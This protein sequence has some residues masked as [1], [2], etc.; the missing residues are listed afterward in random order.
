MPTLIASGSLGRMPGATGSSTQGHLVYAVNSGVWYFFTVTA[1]A[2]DSGTATGA[3]QSTTQFQDTSKS[4]TV[5]QWANFYLYE[6]GGT[7]SGQVI[8]IASNTSNTLTFG[9]ID[10]YTP[11]ASVAGSTIYEIIDARRLRAWVSSGSD[12]STATWSEAT[13]SAGGIV[14]DGSAAADLQGGNSGPGGALPGGGGLG[15]ADGRL[16][17]IG[18]ANISSVDVVQCLLQSQLHWFTQRAR[19]RL[20]ATTITWD[21]VG[22]GSGWISP[23][24]SN[25]GIPFFPAGMAVAVNSNALWF[26]ISGNAQPN[27]D[28]NGAVDTTTDSG[29]NNLANGWQTATTFD[30]TVNET[31]GGGIAALASG[32]MLAV[33][34][35]GTATADGK[36]YNNLKFAESASSTAWPST[37]TGANIPNLS[38]TTNDPNDWG[39]V[40][41]TTTDIHVVRRNAGTTLEQ[42]R[43]S[44]HSGSWG[45]VTTLPST[46]LTGQLAGSGVALVSDGTNVWCFVIDTDANHSVRYIKWNGTSWDA[47]W[48]MLATGTEVKNFVTATI[49]SDGHQIGV[50][51]TV[52][53]S[54]PFSVNYATLVLVADVASN[55][56]APVLPRLV[57]WNPA[58]LRR[59]WPFLSP[60]RYAYPAA[61]TAQAISLTSDPTS[62]A[63]TSTFTATLGSAVALSGPVVAAGALTAT[64]AEAVALS[65]SAAAVSADTATLAASVALAGPVTGV[66]AFPATVASAVALGG[67]VAAVGTDNGTATVQAALGGPSAGTSTAVA[68]ASLAVAL[69]G[70]AQSV[71]T[72]GATASE[73]VALAASATGVSVLSGAAAEAVALA[74]PVAGVGTA[75]GTASEAVSLAGPV[76]GTSSVTGSA[77][78]QSGTPI[79]GAVAGQSTVSG[80]LTVSV[81]VAGAAAAVGGL[82]A[83]LSAAAALSGPVTATAGLGATAGLSVAAAGLLAATS[84]VG[85]TAAIQAA[86]SGSSA[87]ISTA[88]GTPSLA[89]AL[90]GPVAAVGA[91]SGLLGATV[92]LAGGLG[93]VSALTGSA[94]ASSGTPISG[95]ITGNSQLVATA[96]LAVVASGSVSATSGLVATLLLA[97]ALQGGIAGSGSAVAT[98]TTG[99][100]GGPGKS[101]NRL[102]GQAGNR[103]VGGGPNQTGGG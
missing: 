11:V 30:S 19:A 57:R 72:G 21:T 46:G 58:I 20:S 39:M 82:S 6:T 38:S 56:P 17:A 74:G 96:A 5:N 100:P 80:T 16:W 102:L 79:A 49:R 13:G 90:G 86:L 1:V 92:A 62:S 88:N 59:E 68:T 51:W 8:T 99:L 35:D 14:L 103:S 43:Y 31:W 23:G 94:T 15:P 54:A 87:G 45:T 61:S 78:T 42:I 66:S 3:T 93:V 4:W 85:A 73:A 63:A 97:V 29:G 70:S 9:T 67:P 48:S 64:P 18:Y 26:L 44:G 76:A 50:A 81:A 33:Y 47:S 84:T 34:T 12:L 7:G 83:T 89:A 28:G 37:N 10:G 98:L 91:A 65:G 53:S 22:A 27:M 75:S 60:Q 101:P 77:S 69:S 24:S 36:S 95:G 71:S 41:R 55:S 25:D 52:G 2:S 32:F 40:A